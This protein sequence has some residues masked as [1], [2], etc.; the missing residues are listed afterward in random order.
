MTL[1][2]R[3]VNHLEAEGYM[4]VLVVGFREDPVTHEVQPRVVTPAPLP[5]I[6]VEFPA[7]QQVLRDAIENVIQVGKP[8]DDRKLTPGTKVQFSR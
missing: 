5:G 1:G 7:L 6:L 8:P 4:T 2:Q 3:L